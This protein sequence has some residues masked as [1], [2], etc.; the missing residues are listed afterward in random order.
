MRMY[1]YLSFL[2]SFSL[3]LIPATRFRQLFTHTPV[4]P[5]IILFDSLSP[6]EM[7]TFFAF[8][9]SFTQHVI[10]MFLEI[11][12][13][14][15][16]ICPPKTSGI[17]SKHIPISRAKNYFDIQLLLFDF[18]LRN[19]QLFFVLFGSVKMTSHFLLLNI[20]L[21]KEKKVLKAL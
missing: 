18:F 19:F 4:A 17:F 20:F 13:A 15:V 5:F 7:S 14:S 11:L 21:L 10:L 12:F 16:V 1:F 8:P 9:K 3:V 6:R 2:Y